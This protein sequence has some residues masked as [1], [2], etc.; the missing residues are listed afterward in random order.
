MKFGGKNLKFILNDRLVRLKVVKSALM[1]GGKS[2][3]IWA[4]IGVLTGILAF[5]MDLLLA[6]CLQRFFTSTGLIS[7][8]NQTRFFGSL[9]S[10]RSEGFLLLI[11]GLIRMIMFWLNNAS[12]GMTQVTFEKNCRERVSEWAVWE[13]KGSGGSV[14]N[15]YSDILIGSSNSISTIQF[16]VGRLIMLISS[17][18]VL[19]YY[20]LPLTLAI[21]ILM[22]LVL[23]IQKILDSVLSKSGNKI[24]NSIQKSSEIL[25]AGLQNS[26]YLRIHG[27]YSLE[28]KRFRAVLNEFNNY[29][30]HYYLAAGLRGIMPQFIGLIYITVVASRRGTSFLD[31]PG[32]LVAYLY[33]SIRFFQII[34]DLARVSANLRGSWPRLTRLVKWNDE[35]YL[36]IRKEINL[37]LNSISDSHVNSEGAI[38]IKCKNIFFG[39]DDKVIINNFSYDFNEG[40]WTTIFGRSGKGKSTL[41]QLIS[42]YLVPT[43][44]NLETSSNGTRLVGSDA[45]KFIQRNISY[46]EADPVIISGTVRDNLLYG[47]MRDVNN[48]EFEKKL[49]E[50]KCDFVFDLQNRE[51]TILT[52]NSTELSTGQKQRIAI[53]RALMRNPKLLI[54]DEA[55]SNLDSKSE[56]EILELLKNKLPELTIITASHKD[57]Y[58]KFSTQIIHLPN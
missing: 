1:I 28:I 19:A 36:P 48:L 40:T 45:N 42:G 57:T 51:Q 4:S 2:T 15:L 22:L 37:D 55:T 10:S 7:D 11:I 30:K 32:Q 13:G 56:N 25:F 41:L 35:K 12:N 26:L 31:S 49:L 16:L 17:L 18:F 39:W 9:R 50:Y 58:S 24:Q 44:G 43:S 53:F 20:S 6:I 3:T 38:G 29:S 21:F 34:G 52:E 5:V 8:A 54:M 27:L 46:I 23:P 33:L 14:S 47:V